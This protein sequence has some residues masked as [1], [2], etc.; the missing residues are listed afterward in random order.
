M[1]GG[2]LAGLLS[3]RPYRPRFR[4]AFHPGVDP[5]VPPGGSD[6]ALRRRASAQG[7]LRRVHAGAERLPLAGRRRV[8]NRASGAVG[9]L[10]STNGLVFG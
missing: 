6:R 1:L 5:V 3:A 9:V 10:A 4:A 2:R 7:H 8:N